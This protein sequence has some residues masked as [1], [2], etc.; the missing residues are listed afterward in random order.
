MNLYDWFAKLFLHFA[1]GFTRINFFYYGLALVI[2]APLLVSDQL[3][4]LWDNQFF[5]IWSLRLLQIAL[6]IA[7]D[8]AVSGV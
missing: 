3:F 6:I 4:L 2:V 8:G 5:K 7:F 1:D